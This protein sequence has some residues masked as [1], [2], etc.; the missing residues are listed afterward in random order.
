MGSAQWMLVVII[1]IIF[2]LFPWVNSSVSQDVNDRPSD[3]QAFLRGGRTERQRKKRVVREGT[4]TAERESR[5]VEAVTLFQHPR[6]QGL[7]QQKKRDRTSYTPKGTKRRIEI[8]YDS[9]V[10]WT[11]ASSPNHFIVSSFLSLA[12]GVGLPFLWEMLKYFEIFQVL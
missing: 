11:S 7:G 5:S 8:L 4:N 10:L 3:K 2:S 6:P 1:S 9:F 12:F